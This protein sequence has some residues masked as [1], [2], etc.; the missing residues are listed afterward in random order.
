MITLAR[1]PVAAHGPGGPWG[2]WS[3]AHDMSKAVG[4][5]ASTRSAVCRQLM[6]WW[7]RRSH[8]R[9]VRASEPAA[10]AVLRRPAGGVH[11]MMKGIA[12]VS[13]RHWDGRPVMGA[14]AGGR[15]ALAIET[16]LWVCEPPRAGCV[17]GTA[18]VSAGRLGVC[19]RDGLFDG[20]TF[21]PSHAR[22][23]TLTR[24]DTQA[25]TPSAPPPSRRLCATPPQQPAG[26]AIDTTMSSACRRPGRRRALRGHRLRADGAAGLD[27]C[28]R[29]W[30]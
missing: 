18:C 24:S 9:T 20:L 19:R 1:E 29:V 11:Q 22:T 26:G 27:T 28:V 15:S 4:F 23:H 13:H 3:A 12:I 25:L 5:E 14:G 30:H 8:G 7:R 10:R 16:E 21:C 2:A 6:R 17:I